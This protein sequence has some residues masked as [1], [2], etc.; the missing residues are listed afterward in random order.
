MATL[1]HGHGHSN[2]SINHSTANHVVY[3][4][5]SANRARSSFG[6]TIDTLPLARGLC[7]HDG[8]GIGYGYRYGY[9]YARTDDGDGHSVFADSPFESERESPLH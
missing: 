8:G 4:Q 5:S 2:S 6:T 1:G 3:A 9:G 7:Y